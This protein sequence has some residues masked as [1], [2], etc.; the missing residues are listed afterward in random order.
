[1][2]VEGAA[3]PL[4]VPKILPPVPPIKCFRINTASLFD[5]RTM[6]MSTT[7][8]HSNY[9]DPGSGG[10]APHGMVGR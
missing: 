2:L 5:D 7:S 8:S 10:L 9:S 4:G 3:Y 6:Y 1:M